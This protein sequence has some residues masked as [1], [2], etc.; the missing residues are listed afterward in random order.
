M[1]GGGEDGT[2]HRPTNRPTDRP[3]DLDA[4]V[5]DG[6]LGEDREHVAD[7]AL[8]HQERPLHRRQQLHVP[9]RTCQRSDHAIRDQTASR[10]TKTTVQPT[11][12]HTHTRPQRTMQRTNEPINEP[13]NEP[14]PIRLIERGKG[15]ERAR[16]GRGKGEERARAVNRQA[17]FSFPPPV[18]LLLVCVCAGCMCWRV[19]W[20]ACGCVCVC[21]CVL[22]C[23]PR[24][25]VPF[26]DAD[27]AECWPRR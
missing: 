8:P 12:V 10:Q 21:V 4:E 2:G 11:L 27:I 25:A 23:V 1:G 9:H 6:A 7:P 14:T 20:C 13:T 5:L 22:T 17:L 24:W 26:R 19:C 18:C 16:K 3:T 15:E